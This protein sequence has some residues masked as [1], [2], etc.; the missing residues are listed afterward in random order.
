MA[1]GA[2]SIPIVMR[3]GEGCRAKYLLHLLMVTT[4]MNRNG[5]AQD[6]ILFC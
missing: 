5:A 2:D 3:A 6:F 1:Q 4:M